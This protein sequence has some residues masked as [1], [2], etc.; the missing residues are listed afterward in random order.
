MKRI[1]FICI[2][3][4]LSSCTKNLLYSETAPSWVN[5]LRSGNSSLRITSGNKILFRSNYKESYQVEQAEICTKA[6]EKNISFIKKAYPFSAQIPM[7]VELVFFDPKV[8]DCSTTISVSRQLIEKAETLSNLKGKYEK[9]I[10]RIKNETIKVQAALKKANSENNS[11]EN[12]IKELNKLLSENQVY[13]KQI[14]TIEDF[15]ESAKSERLKIKQKIRNY[16]YV[17][18]DS[19]EVSK[20]MADHASVSGWNYGK[21]DTPCDSDEH[22]TRYKDYV[23]CG[24]SVYDKQGFVTKFCN[25]NNWT[26]IEKKFK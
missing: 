17:G 11:L 3:F 4:L 6:I 13:V 24:V 15:V 25:M 20:I 12:K 1:S 14:K 18:M 19:W 5:I 2:L 16:I 9:E 23:V 10:K 21:N 26:C 22:Y 8:N 7:T